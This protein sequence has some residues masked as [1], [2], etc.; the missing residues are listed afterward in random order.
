MMERMVYLFTSRCGYVYAY[1]VSPYFIIKLRR[2][3]MSRHNRI[4]I[5]LILLTAVL[6][7]PSTALAK[8]DVC[9][10]FTDDCGTSV[11]QYSFGWSMQIHCGDDWYSYSGDGAWGGDCPTGWT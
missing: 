2:F 6:S 4:A 8:V 1:Q 10:W 9:S 11:F 3:V 7:V 5:F